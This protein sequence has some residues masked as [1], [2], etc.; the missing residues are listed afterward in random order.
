MGDVG[1][2]GG[3]EEDHN[4]VEKRRE[5]EGEECGQESGLGEAAIS[6][7]IPKGKEDRT[8]GRTITK[9]GPDE[10]AAFFFSPGRGFLCLPAPDPAIGRQRNACRACRSRTTGS[11]FR[12]RGTGSATR[13][14][15]AARKRAP[16]TTGNTW[17]AACEAVVACSCMGCS[18]A[19]SEDLDEVD[20]AEDMVTGSTSGMVGGGDG[21]G[22]W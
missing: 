5:E 2:Q 6:E 9:L 14:G 21:G 13:A 8:E 11:E 12:I 18:C 17:R 7:P 1:E 22:W 3:A 10:S 15:K 4:G 16:K 19:A 20:E